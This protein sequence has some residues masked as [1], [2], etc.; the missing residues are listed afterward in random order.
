MELE[1]CAAGLREA[2]KALR[3]SQRAVALAAGVSP[4]TVKAYEL[5][6]RRPSRAL[7]TAILDALKVERGERNR[8]LLAAGFAPD[9]LSLRP[10]AADLAF[11][12][13]EAAAEVG[14]QPW[15]DFVASELMEVLAANRVAERL[16]GTE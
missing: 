1:E 8:I 10:R 11:S 4:Q 6:L 15:P 7:L 12:L 16:W 14:G 2:R 3:L 13:Q 5:G 9:G